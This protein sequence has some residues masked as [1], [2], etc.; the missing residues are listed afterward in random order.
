VPLVHSAEELTSSSF[1]IRLAGQPASL[2]D[3]FPGLGE[4]DRL[5]VLVRWPCGAVGASALILAAVTAFYDIQRQRSDDFFI[6][7][8][9]F[10]VHVGRPLGDHNMLDIWPRHKEVVVGAA[11]EE[12]LRAINDRAITRLLV[13]DEEPGSPAFERES[14]ASARS[15]IVTALAYSRS[16]RVADADLTVSGNEV[17]G[18]YVSAVLEQSNDVDP[19]VR[20]A[21]AVARGRLLEGGRPT[22]SYRRLTLEEAL[23]RLEVEASGDRSAH[24]LASLP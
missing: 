11:P 13:E 20:R 3:V 1:A 18:S 22:E 24:A 5:G 21:I 23:A 4:H 7:P 14:L 17:T 2:S 9:Y 6:Y 12:I 10:L 16:G 8:D 19:E 15:R